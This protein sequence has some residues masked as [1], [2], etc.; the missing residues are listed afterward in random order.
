MELGDKS[1]MYF[2]LEIDFNGQTDLIVIRQ[3]TITITNNNNAV[4]PVREPTIPTELPPLV[5]NVSA[6]FCG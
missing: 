3:P 2:F 5:G 4:A 6:N 1:K